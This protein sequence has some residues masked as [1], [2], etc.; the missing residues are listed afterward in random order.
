MKPRHQLS[1]TPPKKLEKSLE[2][3]NAIQPQ[4]QPTQ[5][6]KPTQE[7]VIPLGNQGVLIFLT[8]IYKVIYKN[9]FIYFIY[10]KL[11]YLTILY[12]NILYAK[13]KVVQSVVLLKNLFNLVSL[14]IIQFYILL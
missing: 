9:L 3:E 7:V 6:S 8:F 10:K 14:Y 12:N 11:H 1:R 4:Q 5:T 13:F 2:I